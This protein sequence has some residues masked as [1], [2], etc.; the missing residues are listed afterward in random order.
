MN[1]LPDR[2]RELIM[3]PAVSAQRGPRG[4]LV[5]T[6]KYMGGVAEYARTWPGPVTTLARLSLDPI[7]D[8]DPVEYF[9]GDAE[10][11]LELRPDT[12]DGLARRL[13]SAAAV[14]AYLSREEA[15]AADL[16]RKLGVP[17]IFVS[18]YT[19]RTD[20]QILGSE[21][22]NPVIRLRRAVW[23]WRNERIR[24]RLLRDATGLQCS[25]TPTFEAYA[26]LNR[27]TMLFFDNRVRRDEVISSDALKRKLDGIQQ[28]QHLRL[29]FGGRLLPMKGV[30]ELP[31]VA[32]TLSRLGVPFQLD[33]FGTG[34]LKDTLAAMIRDQG[35][36]DRVFLRG[37]LDF[38]SGWIPYLMENADLFVC[39]HVQGD[40]SSTYPEVMSCGVPIAGYANEAFQG[41]VRESGT[42]WIVPLFDGEGLAAEI[43]R[44][45]ANRAEIASHAA[46]ARDF[47]LSNVFEATFRNR[48]RH[49]IRSSRL[50]EA[51]AL[52]AEDSGAFHDRSTE[53]AKLTSR[54]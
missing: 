23:L 3:L 38:R 40:P 26:G 54:E 4:G 22:S 17:I 43:A 10:T 12:T 9:P 41:I 25:G 27:N 39:C 18:E 14:L 30:L 37:A 13:A 15:A 6:E 7:T 52:L 11:G 53:L 24:R 44:L 35:L 34:P 19:L 16:C 42:G 51:T 1:S 31:K 2:S 47:A 50:P 33:I 8:M 49:L 32:A 46:R 28:G 20:L 21:V 36:S 5:L 29:V 45:A 48:V